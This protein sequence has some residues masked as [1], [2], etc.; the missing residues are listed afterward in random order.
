MNHQDTKAPS[1]PIP[2]ETDEVAS[3]IVD[4]AFAVHTALGPVCW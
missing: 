4:A 2:K 3:K 1:E